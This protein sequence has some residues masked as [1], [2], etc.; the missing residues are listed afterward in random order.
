MKLNKIIL[1]IFFLLLCV[2][3]FLYIVA[4]KKSTISEELKDFAVKDTT[5]ISKI[6]LADMSGKSVTL[7]KIDVG[8]WKVNNKYIARNDCI[9]VLLETMMYL[10]VKAPV[11]RSA[12]NSVVKNLSTSAVKVEIYQKHRKKDKLIK[13]YY[14]GGHTQDHQGTYMIL[15]N[16]KTKVKSSTA[17]IMHIPG[18]QGYLTTRY[19]TDENLWRDRKIFSYKSNEIISI[20]A[21]YPNTPNLSFELIINHSSS[22]RN[23]ITIKS[24][25]GNVISDIDTMKVAHYLS[26]YRNIQFEAIVTQMD[27]VKRDSIIS[28]Q[29]LAI[30]TVEDIYGTTTTVK[31]FLREAPKD[32]SDLTE[33]SLKTEKYD[34]DRM[35]GTINDSKELL[36]LQYYVFDHILRPIDYFQKNTIT[37]E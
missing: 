11:S 21:E 14:V 5:I 2:S 8:K 33:T 22:G 3:I 20:K 37:N 30:L 16:T 13:S 25:D 10:E 4:N 32:Y 1:F 36:L 17:F 28:S 12:H 23:E 31:T 18:F 26:Y 35:Y 9:N 27:T 34:R 19:F 15:E 7:E 29:A 6:F 24:S